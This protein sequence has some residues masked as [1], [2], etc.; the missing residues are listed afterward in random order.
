[1]EITDD[2]NGFDGSVK[3]SGNGL[4]NMQSRVEELGGELT[5]TGTPA[6]GTQI[7][8]RLTYPFKMARF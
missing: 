2:G 7:K 5:V 1:M 3:G 8:V 4:K 6:K